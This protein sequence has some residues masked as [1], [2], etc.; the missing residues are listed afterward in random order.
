ML[1]LAVCPSWFCLL[2][3]LLRFLLIL[4]DSAGMLIPAVRFSLPLATCSAP[5]GSYLGEYALM[6]NDRRAGTVVAREETE[7]LELTRSD[8]YRVSDR[9]PALNG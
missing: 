4:A 1:I 8:Y 7:L 6:V 3:T 9:P 2:L 5:A